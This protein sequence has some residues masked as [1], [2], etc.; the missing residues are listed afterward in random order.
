[1]T[2]HVGS[3]H[4]PLDWDDKTSGTARFVLD[5]LD[6]LPGPPLWAAVHRSRHA[7][8]DL[9]SVDT[10][11]ARRMP[12]LPRSSR[13]RTS[14]RSATSRTCPSPIDARSPTDA[15]ASAARRSRQSLP[16]RRQEAA[17]ASGA[18]RVRYRVRRAPFTTASACEPGATALHERTTGERNVSVR[19]QGEHGDLAACDGCRGPSVRHLPL[20]EVAQAPMEPSACIASWDPVTERMELWTTTQAPRIVTEVVAEMLGLER[21]Q[22]VCRESVVGGGFGA[23][24]RTCEYEVLTA[25]LSLRTGRPVVLAFTRED[26]FRT[27]RSRHAFDTTMTGYATADGRASW[28]STHRSSWT[29]APTT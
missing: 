4:R 29:T 17:A 16:R 3:R 15:C 24:S 26:E 9:R 1:M 18:I 8:A 10:S 7:L 28:V 12:G 20:P 19:D 23:R 6:Q 22:V 14:G 2:G 5:G 27:S 13:P 11:R 25:M 21:R